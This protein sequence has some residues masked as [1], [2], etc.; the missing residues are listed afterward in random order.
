MDE[1]VIKAARKAIKALIGV[2]RAYLFQA[3]HEED[4]DYMAT[5]NAMMAVLRRLEGSK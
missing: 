1:I 4:E 5:F 3:M 2:N